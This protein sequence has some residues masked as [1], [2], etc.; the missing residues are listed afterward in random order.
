MGAAHTARVA[1]IRVAMGSAMRG[2]DGNQSRRANAALGIRHPQLLHV[3]VGGGFEEVAC[4]CDSQAGE[5][6]GR[7]SCNRRYPGESRMAIIA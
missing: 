7:E 5:T 3:G 1:K 4:W 2:M 6:K